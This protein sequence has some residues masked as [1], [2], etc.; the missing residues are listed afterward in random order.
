M[1]H[2]PTPAPVLSP[3]RWLNDRLRAF[4]GPSSGLLRFVLIAAVLTAIFSLYL[5]QVNDLST[6][7]DNTVTLQG[8]AYTLEQQN[9]VLAQQLAQWN[10]P[11]YVDERSTQQGYVVAAKRTIAAPRGSA[12]AGE[13]PVAVA[14]SLAPSAT[15]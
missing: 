6:L 5:W 12:P 1:L 8:Q 10:A 14:L 11:T 2:R 3:G 15:R 4:T 13:A 9:V 7:H